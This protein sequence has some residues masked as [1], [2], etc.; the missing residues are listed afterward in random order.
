MKPAK[1]LL[2]RKLCLHH[3]PL[4]K[5]FLVG[6]FGK[7]FKHLFNGVLGQMCQ[8]TNFIQGDLVAVRRFGRGGSRGSSS[9]G[10]GR[11]PMLKFVERQQIVVVHVVVVKRVFGGGHGQGFR[12]HG[13]K[14]GACGGIDAVHD[15]EDVGQIRHHFGFGNVPVAVQV[16]QAEGGGGFVVHVTA[17]QDGHAT[18]DI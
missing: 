7:R 17:A 15:F 3:L 16:V 12:G 13:A 4:E 5:P 14:F 8:L 1:S 11:V 9:G 18:F 2:T 10:V 6:G